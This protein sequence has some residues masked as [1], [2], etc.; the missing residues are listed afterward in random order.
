MV[1]AS[2]TT[3]QHEICGTLNDFN[4]R[5]STLAAVNPS[6]MLN[7]AIFIKLSG[8]MS[9][10]WY[11]LFPSK[12]FFDQVLKKPLRRHNNF[13]CVLFLTGVRLCTVFHAKSYFLHGKHNHFMSL[14]M[15][16]PTLQA[17]FKP[18]AWKSFP[19]PDCIIS[20]SV[21]KSD[22]PFG[23]RKRFKNK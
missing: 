1:C 4:F 8:H 3:S 9:F 23:R 12:T 15:P 17:L 16:K 13:T 18:L 20:C 11:Y 22:S 19:I 6:S 5:F 2:P 7:N 21:S 14:Q 10:Y